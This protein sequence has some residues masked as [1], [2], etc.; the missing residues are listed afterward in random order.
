M[1]YLFNTQDNFMIANRVF[2]QNSLKSGD[3]S[4]QLFWSL[5]FRQKA[6]FDKLVNRRTSRALN[7]GVIIPSKINQKKE[8][9][10][11]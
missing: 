2:R 11:P 6:S 8:Y 4:E 7:K 3:K 9:T 5:H 10:E 1:I